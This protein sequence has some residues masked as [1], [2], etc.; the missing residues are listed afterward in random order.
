MS[1]FGGG[2]DHSLSL[3][4]HA[5]NI[6]LLRIPPPVSLSACPTI[7][8]LSPPPHRA[9]QGQDHVW[10]VIEEVEHKED[11][12]LQARVQEN[13]GEDAWSTRPG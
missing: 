13:G 6:H 2:F 10:N 8:S 3:Y 7:P 1:S 5:R 9:V 4:I 11:H 12:H